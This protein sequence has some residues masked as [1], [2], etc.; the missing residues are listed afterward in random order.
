[1]YHPD[2]TAAIAR[3]HCAD[4]MAEARNAKL[5]REARNARHTAGTAPRA[6]RRLWVRLI[7]QPRES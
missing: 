3:Q 5:A 7:P 1:M 6:G 2:I 4:L